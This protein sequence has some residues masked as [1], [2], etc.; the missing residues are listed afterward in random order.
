ME[1]NN[2]RVLIVSSYAPPAI[3]GPQNMYNLLIDVPPE[4]YRIL[5]SFYNIDNV[6][7][8]RGTWLPGKYLFYD[9][10]GATKDELRNQKEGPQI[11]RG[12]SMVAK[13]KHA[14]KRILFIR[15]LLGAPI[16]FSQIVM[17]YRQGLKAIQKEGITSILG[18]SDYGPALI[19][20]YL[21]HKKTGVPYSLFLFD[22]YRGNFFPFPG[23]ILSR[24]YEK[25]LFE[26]AEKII[27]TNKGTKEYFRKEYGDEMAEKMVIVY[28]ATFPEP[29]LKH[30][31]PYNPKP[32]YTIMFTGRIYWPQMRSIKNLIKAVEKMENLDVRLKIYTPS[33]KD[34]LEKIGIKESK[35]VSLDMAT[36]QEMPAIQAKADILFLPLSWKTKS[37]P[38]I[39]TATPGKF[40][41]YL[42]SGRPMLI[43]APA[44][45]HVVQYAKENHA[46]I[47][48]DEE[49]T[50][51]L[52]EAIRRLLL[53]V[54][55]SRELIKNAQKAFFKN[56]AI[57]KNAHLFR[58]EVFGSN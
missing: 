26:N 25:R 31:T 29:Y 30:Q 38:I 51:V 47:C 33:P 37:Q 8:K 48:A 2:K 19:G 3:G 35:R 54:D 6:S 9:K 18:F 28:N 5:T 14:V 15:T 42:I 45:T 39:D 49:S 27:V 53:D 56:H 17:V 57:E 50:E 36:P 40:T 32:P 12:R 55:Y 44:S 41:D 20:T 13:L 22:L 43:H 34:Y 11:D 24:M 46:A 7:A 10:P 16:I 23:G 52:Q 58:L 21:I 1:K 4:S